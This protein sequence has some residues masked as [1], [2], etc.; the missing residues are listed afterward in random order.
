[1]QKIYVQELEFGKPPELRHFEKLEVLFLTVITKNRGEIAYV[2][3]DNIQIL[4]V[5]LAEEVTEL[6]RF[7]SVQNPFLKKEEYTIK[8]SGN[9][10][11]LNQTISSSLLGS[12]RKTVQDFLSSITVKQLQEIAYPPQMKATENYVPEQNFFGKYLRASIS[13]TGDELI[14]EFLGPKVPSSHSIVNRWIYLYPVL[15]IKTETV[16][17]TYMTI[18]GELLE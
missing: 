16:S 15:D 18:K 17:K 7:I 2:L 11:K 1:M 3:Q 10:Q 8:L 6:G 12:V 14:L 13:H 9:I 5:L 4:S